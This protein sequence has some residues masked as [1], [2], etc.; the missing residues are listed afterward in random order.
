[1]VLQKNLK[2]LDKIEVLGCKGKKMTLFSLYD[3]IA[4]YL[5]KISDFRL[6]ILCSPST[7]ESC[8]SDIIKNKNQISRFVVSVS[9][10]LE[11][12]N[13]IWHWAELLELS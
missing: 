10:T 6:Y 9:R 3:K 12:K 1:M 4:E 11:N 2:N 5:G 13:A 7:R 8:K